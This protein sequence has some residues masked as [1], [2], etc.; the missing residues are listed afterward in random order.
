MS[1]PYV[2][3]SKIFLIG[4]IVQDSDAIK[5]PIWVVPAA[6]KIVA[7]KLGA[8]TDCAKADT[9]YN[10]FKLTD[11]TNIIASIANGP[12][13]SAGTSFTAGD[14]KAMTLVSAQAERAADDALQ[15]EVTKTGNGLALSGAVLQIDYYE[16]NA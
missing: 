14:F 10:T 11:G 12:D 8:D 1:R 4:D 16:Y 9:N 13:S 3:K 2:K 7:A 5:T 6:I 15:F